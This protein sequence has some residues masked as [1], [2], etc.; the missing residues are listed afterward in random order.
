MWSAGTTGARA[1]TAKEGKMTDWNLEQIKLEAQMRLEEHSHRLR[2]YAAD[3][4]AHGCISV[5]C[6]LVVELIERA[7]E[8][9]P[10][11]EYDSLKAEA[12]RACA[13][14]AK[15]ANE[16]R[17]SVHGKPLPKWRGEDLPAPL[18]PERE[19]LKRY[20]K[21]C[22]VELICAA[23]R[24]GAALKDVVPVGFDPDLLNDED[25]MKLDTVYS[26]ESGQEPETNP[27]DARKEMARL[28]RVIQ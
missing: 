14:W 11:H 25:A 28:L 1:G 2:K 5:P 10:K 26:E 6:E 17:P 21:L 3:G 27:H 9:V 12:E 16:T 4:T 24:E 13:A 7:E 22:D 8:V 23:L 18:S 20:H 19:M 15:T